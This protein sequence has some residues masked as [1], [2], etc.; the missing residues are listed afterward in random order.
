LRLKTI[1]VLVTPSSVEQVSVTMTHLRP[2]QVPVPD[3]DEYMECYMDCADPNP[4]IWCCERRG[5]FGWKNCLR[6][7]GW[8]V[9]GSG[10]AHCPACAQEHLAVSSWT[11]SLE[12]LHRCRHVQDLIGAA[13]SRTFA[14]GYPRDPPPGRI[15]TAPGPPSADSP[16][17]VHSCPPPPT[18]EE[19]AFAAA[20][21]PPPV[22]PWN[23][24]GGAKVGTQQSFLKT[25]QGV[26][27]STLQPVSGFS[28]C[29]SSSGSASASSPGPKQPPPSLA[30]A[31]PKV[32]AKGP[33]TPPPVPEWYLKEQRDK[34][35]G[36]A[37][38]SKNQSTGWP[39]S[40]Q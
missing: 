22:P 15:Q 8:G 36:P 6:A 37:D 34:G 26:V 19:R 35:A 5:G 10:K 4:G 21:A 13:G 16:G 28:G 17:W 20:L 12:V 7:Q 32:K 3:E 33:P 24:N 25:K 30:G 29:A 38:K 1:T 31:T 40:F 9:S 2:D 11:P 14:A 27:D 39:P 18:E 23:Q